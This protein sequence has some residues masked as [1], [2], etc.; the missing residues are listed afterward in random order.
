MLKGLENFNVGTPYTYNIALY[1]AN[2]NLGADTIIQDSVNEI[3]GD[4]YDEGGK[5][6]V[7]IPPASSGS[8]A[9]VSFQPVIWTPARFTA[10]GALIY[11]ASTGYAVA[12][13]NFGADKTANGTFTIT[14]PTAD[15]NNA[16]LRIS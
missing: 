10:R 13:L 15:A 3:T 1:N 14:F 12:V 4:G 7:I 5:E 6:L 9:Y 2:A 11:N 8:T 16:I